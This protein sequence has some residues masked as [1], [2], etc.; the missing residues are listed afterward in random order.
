MNKRY[1]QIPKEYIS[2]SQ[3]ELYNRDPEQYK[4]IYFDGRDEL[5]TTNAGQQYG[6][7]VADA[8]EK[9]IQTGDLLTD[10]AMLLLPKYDVADVEMRVDMKVKGGWIQLFAKP[11]SFDS[12]TKNFLEY[13]T[14]KQPWTQKK[15]QDHLQMHFYALAIYCKYKVIPDARL[16]W[17]ETS[18]TDG[19][20]N[21]TGRVQEFIVEFDL[22]GLLATMALVSKVAKEIEIAFAA[23]VPNKELLEY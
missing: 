11:D 23:H 13:K 14:G 16:V 2:Y 9:G 8:L 17:I 15:A 6:K 19:R 21:P 18:S 20:V 5:R 22:K 1:I 12:K 7:V 10:S 4:A 3:L